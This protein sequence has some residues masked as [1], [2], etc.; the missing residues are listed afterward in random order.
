MTTTAYIDPAAHVGVGC[1][2]GHFAVIEAGVRLGD[3]CEIGHHAVVHRGS[4][5]GPGCR[6]ADH[7][8]VGKL[9]VKAALSA[10]T[11]EKPLPPVELGEGVRVGAHAVIYAGTKI[12]AK[13]M[14]AD[15]AF[16]REDVEIGELTI[17]GK[18]VTV[19]N[20]C[21]IGARC[22]LETNAYICALSTI[23]DG[24][25]IAPEVTFT[26]DNFVGRTKERFQHHKG[27]TL[28]LGARIGANATV[29]PG[30][31][32]GE[33]ALVAA[34]SV[35]T[36]DVPARMIVRGCPARPWMPVP[37]EQLLENQ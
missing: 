5:L 22:K 8:I 10:I 20:R 36:R 27:V 9:P 4:V 15:F 25:F 6:L 19:E 31:E 26:N 28:R 11:Q 30:L 14:V 12:G 37:K 7:A 23:A 17:V 29:L 34:G 18:G 35:V 3:G 2:I 13:A 16:V 21:R 32:I 24:C 1:T 33:D